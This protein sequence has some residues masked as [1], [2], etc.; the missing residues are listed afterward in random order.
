[1]ARAYVDG[2]QTSTGAS[3][4]K[5]LGIPQCERDGKTL[6]QRRT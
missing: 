6:A 1:M 5:R 2:F 3:E 4:I